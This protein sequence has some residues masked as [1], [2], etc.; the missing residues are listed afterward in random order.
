MYESKTA[1]IGCTEQFW[2]LFSAKQGAEFGPELTQTCQSIFQKWIQNHAR[3]LPASGGQVSLRSR[4]KIRLG[5]IS[6]P[7]AGKMGF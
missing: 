2:I 6:P 5:R 1:I 7:E 4:S 3:G